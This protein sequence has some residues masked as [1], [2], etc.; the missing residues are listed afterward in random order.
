MPITVFLVATV[1]YFQAVANFKYFCLEEVCLALLIV[2]RQKIIKAALEEKPLK[3]TKKIDRSRGL[4]SRKFG[5]LIA[6]AV[7][8]YDFR[9]SA[10]GSKNLS[11]DE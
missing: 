10:T 11:L 5:I 2:R 6:R 9:F 3:M 1:G 7:S 4:Y 8:I